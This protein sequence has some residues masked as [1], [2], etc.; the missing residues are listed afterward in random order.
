MSGNIEVEALEA[1]MAVC[2]SFEEGVDP[3]PLIELRINGCVSLLPLDQ[4]RELRDALT[5]LEV[6]G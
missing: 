3:E 5:V 6:A 2:L 1:G 4:A